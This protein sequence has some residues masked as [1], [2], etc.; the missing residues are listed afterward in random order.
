MAQDQTNGPPPPGDPF[1]E[2]PIPLERDRFLRGLLR[3]LT[4]T[5]EDVIGVE[6]ATGFIR[7]VGGRVGV[8]IDGQYRR[9]LAV[10]HLDKAALAKV[11]VD[12]KRRIGGDFSIEEITDRT[13]RLVNHR[14][15]F[16]AAVVGRPSLCAMTS[17]VFGTIAAENMGYARVH[18][19]RAISRGASD[20][21]V[22]IH[23]T[24]PGETDEQDPGD[25]GREFFRVLD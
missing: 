16:G 8:E 18:I 24:P 10:D 9:A 14:C 22:L 5:L 7:V 25:E 15:P 21:Q 2:L 19:P 4:G 13:I 1:S 23:F 3:E 11:L 20:C 12:L 17:T 6:E